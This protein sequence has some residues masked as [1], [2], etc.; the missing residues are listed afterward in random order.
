MYE[1]SVVIPAYNEEKKIES[2]LRNIRKLKRKYQV[3]V[4][5]D[6]SEDNTSDVAAASGY[7][8]VHL[9]KN[10]GKGYACRAGAVRA[11]SESV[12]FMDADFQFDARQIPA[13]VRLLKENDIVIGVRKQNDI[14][15]SRRLSN[16]FARAVVNRATGRN[17]R[18]VLC[19]FRAVR[20]NALAR[21]GLTENRYE[22][23]SEMIIKAVA[24]GLRIAELPVSVKYS[25]GGMSLRDSIS[26][27]AYQLKHLF[28]KNKREI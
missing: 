3:V 24:K 13:F 5:D 23:E 18:D 7:K 28:I 9:K 19:G 10:M 6:G 25:G 12:V 1:A 17:F 26:V 20:K 2:V 14:P 16:K 22:F 27:S 8:A 21:L 4:V 11:K 15:R